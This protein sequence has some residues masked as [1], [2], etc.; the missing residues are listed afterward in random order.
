MAVVMASA[1]VSNATGSVMGGNVFYS[2]AI[3]RSGSVGV[4]NATATSQGAF[5]FL[6]G[7]STTSTA[8]PGTIGN[9]EIRKTAIQDYIIPHAVINARPALSSY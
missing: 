7:Y 4:S 1:G 3:Q 8:L 6:G 9:S 5:P 2:A